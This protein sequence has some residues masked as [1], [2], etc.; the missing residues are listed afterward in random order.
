[1]NNSANDTSADV[2][3]IY[4]IVPA[5]IALKLSGLDFLARIARGDLPSPPF[6]QTAGMELKEVSQG[7]AVFRAFPAESFFNPM[8]TI[9]G[10]WIATVLDSSL[11]CA[12]HTTLQPGSVYSTVEL[13]VRLVRK[14]MPESGPMICEGKIV[15]QGRRMATA[16]ARLL[17]CNGKLAAHGSAT[18]MIFE[19]GAAA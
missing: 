10:G 7:R 8:G 6:A 11:G 13:S 15:H 12:V 3:R 5:E 2:K 16:E 18:C 4:G 1:M 14:V 9:H 19:A 17:D